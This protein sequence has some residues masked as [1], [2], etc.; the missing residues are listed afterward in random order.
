[1][2]GSYL[3][4]LRASKPNEVWSWDFVCDQIINGQ[5]VNSHSFIEV[6]RWMLPICHGDILSKTPR[7]SSNIVPRSY[8]LIET[9]FEHWFSGSC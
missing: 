2:P 7:D 6:L 5:I 4:R 1:M 3:K 8:L 9:G